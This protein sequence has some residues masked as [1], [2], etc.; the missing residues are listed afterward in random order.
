MKSQYV[1]LRYLVY[2]TA[3]KVFPL[4][5][6]FDRQMGLTKTYANRLIASESYILNHSNRVDFLMQKYIIPGGNL[7]GGVDRKSEVRGLPVSH[8]YIIM[9]DLIDRMVERVNISET[10]SFCE[11]GGGFGVNAHLILSNF[12]SIRKYIY[13]DISP[14]LYVA[15]QFLRAHFGDAVIDF[16]HTKDSVDISFSN[17]DDLEVFCVLPHQLEFIK[18]EVDVFH[19]ANSFVE[20]PQEVVKN[21]ATIV[22][23]FINKK[24]GSILL[25]SYGGFDANTTFHPDKLIDCFDLDFNSYQSELLLCKPQQHFYVWSAT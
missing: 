9:L 5:R 7:L 17:D 20:M 10:R 23:G 3:T 25:S 18:E 21:Y 2:N 22:R 24:K 8:H 6:F 1:G 4:N 14:N 16:C 15:T 11:I 19:N 12:P 13:V